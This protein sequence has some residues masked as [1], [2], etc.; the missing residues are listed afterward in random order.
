MT[1]VDQGEYNQNKLPFLCAHIPNHL[2]MYLAGTQFMYYTQLY[3][4]FNI[5]A[6]KS[7]PI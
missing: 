6:E 5:N 1:W 3:Y 4:A 2:P 7:L